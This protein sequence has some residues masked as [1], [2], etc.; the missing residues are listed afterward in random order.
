MNTCDWPLQRLVT[1]VLGFTLLS[2]CTPPAPTT[3][4]LLDRPTPT[5]FGTVFKTPTSTVP[6][7]TAEP[8]PLSTMC[9]FPIDI[10]GQGNSVQEAALYRFNWIQGTSSQILETRDGPVTLEASVTTL[11]GKRQ[12]VIVHQ[13]V[14]PESF[15]IVHALAPGGTLIHDP[16]T[17]ALEVRDT[18]GA[19]IRQT[20]ADAVEDVRGLHANLDITGVERQF[21]AEDDFIIRVTMAMPDDGKYIW[22]FE[23]VEVLLGEER[24]AKRTMHTG[25]VMS[26]HYDHD[27][28]YDTWDGT[29]V[30]QA[31]TI[32]WAFENGGAFPFG[33]H[34]STSAADG[35]NTS[36]FPVDLMQRLWQLSQS[37]CG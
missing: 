3:E 8:T 11:A 7:E 26:I 37:S 12:L 4:V 34:S 5:L 19:V 13:A 6:T 23:T 33:A 9:V 20:V 24:F 25:E 2:G 10:N 32:T 31:N 16:G 27:G 36:I 29:M 22:S 21:S 14:L 18:Q 1:L 30:V 15:E 17:S 35:D 28:N